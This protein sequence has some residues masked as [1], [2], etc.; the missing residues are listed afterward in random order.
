MLIDENTVM[1]F[2]KGIENREFNKL[3]IKEHSYQFELFSREL[4]GSKY[5]ECFVWDGN[6]Y[7]GTTL[8]NIKSTV[9][10]IGCKEASIE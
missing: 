1:I 6:S 3:T 5:V 2:L 7:K 4:N 9:T 10:A 8:K